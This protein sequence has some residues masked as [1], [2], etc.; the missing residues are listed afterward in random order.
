MKSTA[1]LLA[2]LSVLGCQGCAK[3]GGPFYAESPGLARG[4]FAM[5]AP[6]AAPAIGDRKIIWRGTLT[7]EVGHISNT[8][9]RLTALV[10]AQRGFV[11]ST[12]GGEEE[13]W[14]IIRLPAD[15]LKSAIAEIERAGRVTYRD[16]SSTDVTEEYVDIEARRTNLVALR[17]RLRAL[18]DR[19]SE[20]KDIVAIE[21]ELNRVQSELDSLDA[22]MKALKGQIDYATLTVRLAREPILGPLG[23]VAKGVWWAVEKLFVIRR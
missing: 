12:R 6:P 14:L 3:P 1:L 18:L 17:D 13:A 21:T 16:L 11:E 9:A 19:A 23:Y 5:A 20:V 22:R 2:V 7:M 8:I 10:E 4:A 15:A